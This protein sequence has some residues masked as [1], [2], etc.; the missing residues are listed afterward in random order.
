M[1]NKKS[2]RLVL[3]TLKGSNIKEYVKKKY[4]KALPALSFVNIVF[5]V[6]SKMMSPNKQNS[7]ILGTG[8]CLKVVFGAN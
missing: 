5:L 2:Q 1:L 3:Y 8:I 7:V 4:F 6:R